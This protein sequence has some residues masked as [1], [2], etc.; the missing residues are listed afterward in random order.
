MPWRKPG[1]FV[2]VKSLIFVRHTTTVDAPGT[3]RRAKRIRRSRPVE[4]FM[5]IVR[6]LSVALIFTAICSA[7]D[8]THSARSWELLDSTGSVNNYFGW[9]VAIN[10][11]T[12]VVGNLTG[13]VYVYEK[14]A[15]GWGNV[16]Q[17][18][19]L[20][21]SEGGPFGPAVAIS[22]DTIVV[23]SDGNGGDA[24]VFVKPS[25][26][27]RNMTET[28]L[29]TGGVSGDAFGNSVAIDGDTIVVGA[30][31]TEVN[32]NQYQGVAYVFVKPPTG[33][34]STSAF[35]AELT[36]SDGTYYD[37]FG[38]SVGISGQTVV[39]GA[40]FQLW[41]YG[42]GSGVCLRRATNRMGDHDSDGRAN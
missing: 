30:Q 28:A 34:A 24:Y 25:G 29:L 40:P 22:G 31:A 15:G 20:T 27:W 38:A 26:G 41:L 33:W 18:A 13:A 21:G 10:G 8:R 32:G 23:G 4:A 35:N 6:I 11:N 7:S 12:V 5:R 3:P 14:P 17:T 19:E 16:V 37:L 36:S 42:P 9:S 2:L 39:V 1:H